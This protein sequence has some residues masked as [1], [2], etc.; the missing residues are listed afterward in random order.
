[1]PFQIVRNDI[2]KVKADAIV[3]TANPKPKFAG[4]T[5]SAI[6]TAAGKLELLQA[7]KEIGD[8]A[9]GDATVTPA[10]NLDAK[11]I[12]HTVGPAWEDGKQGETEYL[13]SCYEKSLNLAKKLKCESIAFP[14][15]STG[16]FGFPK[17][18]ALQVAI[19]VISK[20][21]MENDMKV[22]LVVFD[23]KSFELSGKLFAGV[24]EFIDE[25]YVAK[26]TKSEYDLVYDIDERD[27]VEY[28]RLRR[29]QFHEMDGEVGEGI[30]E[31]LTAV[32]KCYSN[33]DASAELDGVVAQLGETFQ[34]RLLR[35]VDEKG[36]SDV[37]VYKK[38]N[39]D[40]KLFSKIRCNAEYKPKKK[41]AVALAIALELDL[42]ETEDLL[43]RAEIALSPSNKF[44]L[45]IRYFI[46]NHIYDVYTINVALFKYN[47][48]IL[49]E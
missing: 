18:M 27:E 37:E 13:R 23:R 5:D 3:N 21:L 6:Y 41:T 30:I 16:V 11:Y 8:I 46:M 43:G 15:I 24:D 47:Q 28:C 2:T 20:F 38:A 44:D 49:G 45:I 48:P 39:I 4:G 1:M 9:V 17:D 35:L 19:G 25:H 7:R 26:R 22:I 42:S 34:Q 36:L 33:V 31:P 32:D 10:F 12:I 40:R 14:L 29:R